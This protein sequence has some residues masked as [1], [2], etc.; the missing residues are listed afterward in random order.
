MNLSKFIFKHKIK[1]L[2]QIFYVIN[3]IKIKIEIFYV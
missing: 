3:L 1:K 2:I